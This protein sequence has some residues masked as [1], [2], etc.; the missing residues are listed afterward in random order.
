M[1]GHS[2][3][4]TRAWILIVALEAFATLASKLTKTCFIYYIHNQIFKVSTP[5]TVREPAL[6][7]DWS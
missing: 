7:V 2:P 4:V 3:L 1:I 5:L 6:S